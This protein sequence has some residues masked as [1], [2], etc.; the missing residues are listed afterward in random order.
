MISFMAVS[1]LG[2]NFFLISRNSPEK[3]LYIVFW[4]DQLSQHYR[5]LPSPPLPLRSFGPVRMS[6]MY[7]PEDIFQKLRINYKPLSGNHG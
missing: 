6:K 5:D 7:R 1:T 2:C 4:R 3:L